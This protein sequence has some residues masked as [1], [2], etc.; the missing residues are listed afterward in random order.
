MAKVAVVLADLLVEGTHTVDDL[1]ARL[2][3]LGAAPSEGSMPLDL[4]F[5]GRLLDTEVA[6]RL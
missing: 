4:R 3:G 5:Q 6:L 2:A 1:T